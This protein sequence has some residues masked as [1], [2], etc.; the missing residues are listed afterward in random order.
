MSI[1]LI[2]AGVALA[3]TGNFVTGFLVFSLGWWLEVL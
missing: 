2:A 3:A 1:L